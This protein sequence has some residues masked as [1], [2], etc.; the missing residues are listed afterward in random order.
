ML[1]AGMVPA[2]YTDEEKENI[3][4]TVREEAKKNAGAVIKYVSTTL[5]LSICLH[6]EKNF[7]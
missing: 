3:L 1:T 6:F 4:G 2:L 7:F 5:L